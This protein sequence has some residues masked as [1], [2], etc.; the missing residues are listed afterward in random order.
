L[1]DREPDNPFLEQRRSGAE[2]G[3]PMLDPG[4]GDELHIGDLLAKVRSRWKLIAAM[5]VVSVTAAAVLYAITPKQYRATT[6]V[7]IDRRNLAP[8]GGRQNPWLESLW[9]MEFYPTQYKLLESRG[10]AEKVILDLG[11][12]EDSRFNPSGRNLAR[13][14]EDLSPDQ[15]DLDV[16]GRM[17]GRLLGGLTVS[18]VRNTQLVDIVYRASSPEFAA[19]VA[20]GFADAFI[21][22][23]ID[24]RIDTVGRASTFLAAEIDSLKREIQNK[25][26]RIRAL[27]RD[28]DILSLDQD[29]N[30]ALQ[31]FQT[32]N[33][34]FMQAK[35]QRIESEIRYQELVD[36]PAKDVAEAHAGDTVEKLVEEQRRL[37]QE[38]ET[39]LQTYKPEWP[40]LVELRTEIE[41][42]R[43]NIERVVAE[44]A[45]RARQTAYNEYQAAVRK[46]RALKDELDAQKTELL[47]QSSTAVELSNL[48]VELASS[49]ELLEKLIDQQSETEVAARLQDA[50]ESNVR[51][52]DKALVPRSPFRPSLREN[53]G[54]GLG[55]GLA[56]GIGLVFLLEFMD[57]TLKSP[58]E[59]ERRLGLPSLAV[60][61]DV[62]DAES[63]YGRRQGYGYGYGAVRKKRQPG[64]IRRVAGP[65]GDSEDLE[66]I[67]LVPHERP[68]LS[69]SEAYRAL[70][71]ALLLSSARE[72][73]VVAITSPG[74][75]EGKTATSTNLAVV[76]AQLGR[77]VLLIDGDLRKPRIHEV[78]G[79]SNRTG[80]VSILAGGEDP[81]SVLTASSVK[82]LS[83]I[84]SGPSP[85]NP[86]ELLSSNRMRELLE[87][88]RSRFDFVIIDTPPVLAVT[89]ATVIGSQT[90]GV[91]LCLRAGKVLREDA[92]TCRDRL[93][94]ADVKLL[95]TVLNRHRER[96][97]GRSYHY[98]YAAYGAPESQ[99][100]SA[101]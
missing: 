5:V 59:V 82:N 15:A 23:G 50:R 1:R 38:Y 20:N 13:S 58:E 96:S 68:R 69:V 71:T 91:V 55:V 46:E 26:A 78:F 85:P 31:R 70:R 101:A 11:L 57:R 30:V 35:Q 93:L 63:T 4:S 95:G 98:Y 52:I 48:R 87:R 42:G 88:A 53:V 8:I 29:T 83:L 61:P 73:G 39:K 40:G 22:W 90:D 9:N 34:D 80:L 92:K 45:D 81:A 41:Q 79:V 76:M 89:D 12:A 64:I 51:V 54:M 99:S 100:D 6:R 74:S 44:A 32:Y 49:R 86:S 7:Q 14:S 28:T 62:G 18:P 43:R 75:G 2:A 94:M 24:T 84:T 33:Q 3:A 97:A 27:S 67:E 66:S 47:D 37:E 65:G 17:A 16:L 10:L 56:L 77:R 19:R 25:E 36:T 60:I 21:N 72:L